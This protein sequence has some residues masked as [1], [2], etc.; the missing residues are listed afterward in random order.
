MHEPN[1]AFVGF[2]GQCEREGFTGSSEG[3]F[4]REREVLEVI[5]KPEI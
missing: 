1:L 5:G 3:V 2:F 4:E